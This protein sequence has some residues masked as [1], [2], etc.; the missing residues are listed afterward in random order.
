MRSCRTGPPPSLLTPPRTTES[1]YTSWP[2][3]RPCS[4]D[5]T[6]Q[7]TMTRPPPHQF[8]PQ[9]IFGAI[10]PKPWRGYI[11]KISFKDL[12]ID[13]MQCLPVKLFRL[14]NSPPRNLSVLSTVSCESCSV[15]SI[16]SSSDHKIAITTK[17]AQ[18]KPTGYFVISMWN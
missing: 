15:S 17:I 14:S 9:S 8:N 16:K 2:A 6:Y 4:C 7:Y 11:L 18:T 1:T 13:I 10:S 3:M 12:K 5:P